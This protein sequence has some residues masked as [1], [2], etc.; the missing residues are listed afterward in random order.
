MCPLAPTFF[1]FFIT[2]IS[3]SQND[4]V[5]SLHLLKTT[6]IYIPGNTALYPCPSPPF[7][8]DSHTILTVGLPCRN[9][10]PPTG[11]LPHVGV[12]P[13]VSIFSLKFDARGVGCSEYASDDP[14]PD[15]K[16]NDMSLDWCGP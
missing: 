3:P 6:T 11:D 5:L 15:P 8:G 7:S 1:V 12:F 2:L 16:S 14:Y 13:A 4:I 10:L 9:I